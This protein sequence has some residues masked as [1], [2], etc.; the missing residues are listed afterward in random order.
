MG[1]NEQT[2]ETTYEFGIDFDGTMGR[3]FD[4]SPDGVGV[5]EN[6]EDT[7]KQ[8]FGETILATYLSEGGLQNRAPA[9][10]IHDLY[11]LHPEVLEMAASHA[12][13]N[14]DEL[15]SVMPLTAPL[16]DVWDTDPLKAAT[17]TYI[18]QDLINSLDHI[19]LL[20][21]DGLPWPRPCNGFDS[22]WKTIEALNQAEMGFRINTAVIS[23]GYID[24]IT[25]AFGVWGLEVPDI[26]VT[27]DNTRA[28][29][30][31]ADMNA[32]VKPAP[33]GIA[34][35]HH[36]WLKMHG[37]TGPDFSIETVIKSKD[38][39]FYFGD[40]LSKDGQLA[41][42]SRIGFGHYDETTDGLSFTGEYLRF[43]DWRDIEHCLV[44]NVD[45]LVAGRAL[46]AILYS[47]G[48]GES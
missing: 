28:R 3:T 48:R 47:S 17:E 12:S 22:F 45:A 7:L 24:Y 38:R 2:F 1:A 42:R 13:Q 9:E 4:P 16:L 8:I 29:K 23:S 43:N 39:M 25:K 14:H 31:P 20:N 44:D 21:E 27:D 19:G 41:A 10:V 33:F 35:A 11:Q 18:R 37:Q 32:R 5:E 34:L 30:Y 46:T 36:Q 15:S 6:Y 26:W 40:G